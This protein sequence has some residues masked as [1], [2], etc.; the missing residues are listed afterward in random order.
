MLT[1]PMSTFV[2]CNHDI[3]NTNIQLQFPTVVYVTEY[4]FITFNTDIKLAL[5]I[6]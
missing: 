5:I 3:F 2:D 4:K 6:I 1:E